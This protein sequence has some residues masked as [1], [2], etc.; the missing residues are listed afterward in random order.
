MIIV[1]FHVLYL[2]GKFVYQNYRVNKQKAVDDA[3][4]KPTTRY[5]TFQE[6]CTMGDPEE[7][8]EYEGKPLR[9][10]PPAYVQRYVAVTELLNSS[11]YQGK[12]RKVLDT[13]FSPFSLITLPR[14]P[15]FPKILRSRL[16]IRFLI[17]V[18]RSSISDA[19]NSN[20]WST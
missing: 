20:F 13:S 7:L 10:F 18:H 1:L 2:F 19:R 15:L 8:Q 9:F 11:K 12:L 4:I 3:V 17:L 16:T 6:G 5:D 14:F